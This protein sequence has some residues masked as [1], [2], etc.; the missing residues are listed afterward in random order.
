MAKRT[1]GPE[2]VAAPVKAK[3][4]P[5][6]PVACS[7]GLGIDKLSLYVGKSVEDFCPFGYGKKKDAQNHCA[8]FVSH[9]LNIQVG[10]VCSNL[11]PWTVKKS[12]IDALFRAGTRQNRIA[13]YFTE[14][15]KEEVPFQGASTRVN[16]IYNSVSKESKGDWDARPEPKDNCL[17]YVTIPGNIPKD[18]ARMGEMSRKHIGIHSG[19]DIYHYGNTDDE[20]KRDTIEEFQKKFKGNYGKDAIFLWSEIPNVGAACVHRGGGLG[21]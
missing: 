8:H 9:A 15:G 21:E 4:K 16:E 2:G 14:V 6:T 17:I 5:I 11:L 19:G 7:P 1:P 12:S 20:V 10:S 3:A 13:G 18:R